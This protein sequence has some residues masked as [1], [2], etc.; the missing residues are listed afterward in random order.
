MRYHG[1][2]M[3]ATICILG[4]A[5]H[6]SSSAEDENRLRITIKTADLVTSTAGPFSIAFVLTDGS[7]IQDGES[8]V[9]VEDFRYDDGYPLG[10]PTLFGG[11]R[12]NFNAEVT[13][14]NDAPVS[15][16]SQSFYP[17]R[18]LSFVLS[19]I[20]G[21]QSG[22]PPSRLSVF[23]LDRSGKPIATLAPI[24]DFFVGLDLKS[25]AAKPQIFGSNPAILPYQG[26]PIRIPVPDVDD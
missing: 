14:T 2:R 23:L 15:F 6:L 7:A 19:R 26:G 13:L 11:T 25:K 20:T 8:S 18:E 24:G 17:G 16:Y 5:T 3:V 4:V 10:H 1:L 9:R 21:K 22:G 12:R